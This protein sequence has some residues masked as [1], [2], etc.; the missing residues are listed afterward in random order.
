[1]KP[2]EVLWALDRMYEHYVDEFGYLR[3]SSQQAKDAR[4]WLVDLVNAQNLPVKKVKVNTHGNPLPECYGEWVDLSAAEDVE[5]KKGEFRIISL[6]V[7]MQLPP[8]FY[9]KVAPRSST[10]GKYGIL[11]ANSIG[12]I[13]NSYSG[14]NDVWGFPAY[15]I[16]DTVIEKGTRIAQFC[17][18]PQ[19]VRLEFEQVEKLG[20]DDRG[21]FGSTGD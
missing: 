3:L 11:M 15:A 7:S 4:D 12:I 16:R 13:E 2:S 20:N 1:M 5:M 9:A 19:E 14:D 6:G 8:G 10:A 17:V 21:G 18:V